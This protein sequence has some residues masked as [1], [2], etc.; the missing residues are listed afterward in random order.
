MI[1]QKRIHI[2][3]KTFKKNIYHIKIDNQFGY[4]NLVTNYSISMVTRLN[5]VTAQ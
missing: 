3:E 4:Y 5:N 2:Y 1:L